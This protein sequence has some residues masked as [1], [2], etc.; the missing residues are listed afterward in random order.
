MKVKEKFTKD[1]CANFYA[2]LTG[3]SKSYVLKNMQE[4]S[5]GG[6]RFITGM[7]IYYAWIL[8][9]KIYCQF[10]IQGQCR[11]ACYF[12]SQ[13]FEYDWKFTDEEEHE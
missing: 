4:S 2:H 10:F 9:G 5:N 8:K 6:F 3:H 11:D 13:T 12:D 1:K 7:Q